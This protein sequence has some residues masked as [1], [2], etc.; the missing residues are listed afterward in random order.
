MYPK[1]RLY[2]KLSICGA[3]IAS[4]VLMSGC[5]DRI[6]INDI[7]LIT[8]TAYDTAPEG[9]LQ[10]SVQ[11]MLPA[12]GG[13][14]PD[15]GGSGGS[16]QKSF[17][18]ETAI[19][20]DPGDGEKNIQRKFPRRLFRGHRRVII[21]GE[22]L[23]KEGLVK[24]LDSIGRDPQNRL[25]TYVMVA[26][27]KK[28]VE[29]LDMEYPVERV[30]SEAM[31]EMVIAGIKVNADIRDFLTAA[32]SEGTQPVA[33]AIEPEEGK[34]GFKP[35]GIAL[36]RDLKLAG[37]LDMEGTEG[38]LWSM[39]N[40]KKSIVATKIPN[41][42]VIRVNVKKSSAKITPKMKGNTP[43]IDILIK[44]RGSIYGNSTNL[45]LTI[46][47][48]LSLTQKAIRKKIKNQIENTIKTVQKEY[49]ADI[50]GF[51]SYFMQYKPKE[52][53]KLESK[54]NDIFPNIKVTVSVDFKIQTSGMSGPALYLKEKE[55]KKK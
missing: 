37:F 2:F 31:R 34:K 21:I 44:G 14:S 4:T 13:Q 1:F 10:Y 51:G 40:Y 33:I 52:W 27:G 19:G 28:G 7:A 46:P 32:S 36:F 12:G 48:Y 30:P 11:I 41:Q 15:Q 53:K 6:E 29:M 17:I 20:I 54:W 35:V 8:A 49:G 38:Y 39:G 5:W 16:K 50:F 55:V 22:E 25:R 3:L 23:A 26:K 45:D 18:V 47:K 42:G 43:S 24:M 9:K